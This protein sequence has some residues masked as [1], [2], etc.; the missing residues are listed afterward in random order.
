[1]SNDTPLPPLNEAERYTVAEALRYLH[2]RFALPASPATRRSGARVARKRRAQLWSAGR[3][4][5]AA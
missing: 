3:G 4:G 1:M 2:C 5:E